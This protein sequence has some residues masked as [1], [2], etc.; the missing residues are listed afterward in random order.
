[1]TL[2][3]FLVIGS[4][5]SG[6][7][8]LHHYLRQHPEVFVPSVKAPSYFYALD[9]PPQAV[10]RE[11]ATR[12]HFVRDLDAY[13]ALFEGWMGE[14]AIGEV[15]PAYLAS[16]RVAGRVREALPDVRLIAVLR[17]PIERV[18]AR[19]VARRRDGL[20][21]QPTFDALVDAELNSSPTFGMCDVPA[22]TAGTYLAG[23]F[24]SHILQ[25]HLELASPDRI[26]CLLF[27]DLRR[28]HSRVMSDIF[29]F[30][31]VDPNIAID[32]DTRHN[33]SGGTIANPLTR[34]VWRHSS[35]ARSALRPFVPA[36]MRDRTFHLATRSTR[37]A[38]ISPETQRRLASLYRPEVDRLAQIL[39]R[40]LSHWCATDGP[41]CH[42]PDQSL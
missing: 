29:A 9:E 33:R 35:G 37:R 32:T 40:D 38:V 5:R 27:D 21:S 13:E 1:M 3:N 39:G 7:T 20:E 31:G 6:T 11:Q 42:G 36:S 30:L 25:T 17:D 28:E 14:A 34:A 2:P 8:S 16:V 18:H 12:T 22:D 41:T 26:R 10:Q 24:V 23:G 15:S 19:Y 4:G